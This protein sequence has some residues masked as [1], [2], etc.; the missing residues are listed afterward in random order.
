MYN[1]ARAGWPTS[2]PWPCFAVSGA[3]PKD[4]GF[5]PGLGCHAILCSIGCLFGSGSERS[6]SAFGYTLREAWAALPMI[7]WAAS[8]GTAWSA[9]RPLIVAAVC[10]TISEEGERFTAPLEILTKGLPW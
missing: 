2:L 4:G 10:C 8:G 6:H 9:P 5:S 7:Q 1:L 3:L